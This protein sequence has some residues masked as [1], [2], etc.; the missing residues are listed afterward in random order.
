MIY[1]SSI[2]PQLPGKAALFADIENVMIEAY[3]EGY[4]IE[5]VRFLDDMRRR[6]GETLTHRVAYATWNWLEDKIGR[7]R[8]IRYFRKAGFEVIGAPPGHNN[9]DNFLI[10]DAA[11]AVNEIEGLTTLI[12]ITN[13]IGYLRLVEKA[14]K[15]G[16]KVILFYL[17]HG[18]KV[19]RNRVD[20][21]HDLLASEWVTNE[22]SQESVLPYIQKEKGAVQA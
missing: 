4:K 3:K 9:A 13:D 20:E 16:V 2:Q 10:A 12:L 7:P 18:S 14:Q 19:L 1:L 15:R 6:L 17:C 21:A 11:M 8:L 22:N 5:W